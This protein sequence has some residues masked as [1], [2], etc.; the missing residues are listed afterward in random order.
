MPILGVM[1]GGAL[2]ALLRYAI[3]VLAVHLVPSS[4]LTASSL[5][6]LFVNVTGSFLLGV[7]SGYG[8]ARGL[9]PSLTVPLAT[10]FLGSLTTFSTFAL[11]SERLLQEGQELWSVGY[12]LASVGLGLLALHLG[13][14]WA[15]A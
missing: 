9:P 11:E 14:L 7:L 5:G 12:V 13:R 6:T 15:S 2:G 1:L 4:P 10:G 3:A 8:S